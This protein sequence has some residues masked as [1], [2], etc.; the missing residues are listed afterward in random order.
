VEVLVNQRSLKFRVLVADA[1]A[2]ASAL[3]AIFSAD[4]EFGWRLVLQI[5]FPLVFGAFWLYLAR[6]Q[7]PHCEV[8]LSQEFPTGALALLPLSKQPCK[9]CRQSL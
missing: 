2:V 5:Q 9:V 1:I 3:L 6:L 8:R 4:G 7:C